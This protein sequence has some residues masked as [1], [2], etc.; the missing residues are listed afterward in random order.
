MDKKQT[1]KQKQEGF[2]SKGFK[3]RNP[4]EMPLV[5][6]RDMVV[7]PHIAIPVAVQRKG[8]I[9]AI[10]FAMQHGRMACFVTQKNPET[11]NPGEKD[12]FDV[13]VVAKIRE[14]VKQPDGTIRILI[15]GIS[16]M[17]IKEYIQEEPF[18]KVKYELQAEVSDKKTEKVEA[19]MYSVINLFKECVN[20]GVTVPLDVL[21]L[22]VNIKNPWRLADLV[23]LHVNFKLKEKQEILEALDIREKLQNVSDALSRQ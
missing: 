22:I 19:L 3:P 5:P 23:A 20:L 14:I 10:D 7:F 6:I 18:I 8:S 17:K 15:E 2:S 12:L 9:K 16:R 4:Q 13:G 1:D 21:L 11:D